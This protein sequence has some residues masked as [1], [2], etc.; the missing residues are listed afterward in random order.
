MARYQLILA[1]DGTE[2]EGF[3]RQGSKRTVQGVVE[4]ALRSLNWDG[5]A[6]L[7]AGR[8]D[9][10]VHASGQVIA[11]DLDWTH[12]PEELGR[13]LNAALPADVAVKAVRVARE[14]FHPRYDALSRTYRYRITCQEERDPLSERY[15]WRIWPGAEPGLLQAAARELIGPHDFAAFGSPLRHGGST[16]RTVL[17]ASWEQQAGFLQFEITANAF[18]YRMVRRTVYLLVRVG[19]GRLDLATFTQGVQAAQPQTPGLAPPN[20]LSLVRV[21]YGDKANGNN[22]DWLSANAEARNYEIGE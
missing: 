14:D 10:G 19:Q 21:E 22:N 7:A 15:A 6:L 1:Y 5:R 3:Q 13:A 11:F 4:Q 20:G 17:A 9:S 18:L 12:T 16:I 8:T 2:L